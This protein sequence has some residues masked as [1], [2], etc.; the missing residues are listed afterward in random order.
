MVN[1]VLKEGERKMKIKAKVDKTE[2]GIV[3]IFSNEDNTIRFALYTYNDDNEIIYLSN[4]FVNES[5]RKNGYGDRIIEWVFGYAKSH[6]FKTIILNVVKNSWM[7]K[8]Y[9]RKGFEYLE[10]C[11]D[12]EYKGNVWLKKDLC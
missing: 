5:L 3:K 6:S 1:E 2:W 9:K 11:E 4:L 8:W 12:D 7:E 10:D